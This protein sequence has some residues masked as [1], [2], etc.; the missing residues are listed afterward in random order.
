MPITNDPDAIKIEIGGK[1]WDHW[2][3]L[4]VHIG[5]DT[6]PTAGFSSPWDPSRRDM[7]DAF[8]PC[9][10][11]PMT[12]TRGNVPLFSG[13]IIDP[14]PVMQSDASTVSVNAY[15]R[16]AILEDSNLP[17]EHQPFEARG[18]TL[19]QVAERLAGVYGIGVA[20]YGYGGAPFHKVN[21]KR[22]RSTVDTKVDQE[23]KIDDFLV[24]LAKQR[25]Y[26]RTSDHNGDLL[27]W[28]S[29]K[30]GNPVA[31]L[32]QGTPGVTE[33]IPTFS[34]RDYYSEITG[35]T[36]GKRGVTSSSFTQRNNRLS[37]V[38]LRAMSFRLDDVEKGDAPTAVAAKYGRMLA[39][40]CTY[41]VHVPSW[42]GPHGRVWAVN[43][44]V[45]LEAPL[46]MVYGEYEFLVRDVYLKENNHERT[47][48]LGL[49]VPESFRGEIPKRMPWDE[50][51]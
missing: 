20:I 44:T 17:A 4:E 37:G 39:N 47:A 32:R 24:E 1:A 22:Y 19:P 23:T 2:D 26:V 51:L 50:P 27:F 7:R 8:R 43:E 16:A 14:N 40:A 38:V 13:F 42:R 21:T 34:P 35:Y 48:S 31:R 10:Y 5:L 12:L 49:V 46:A 33:V 45:T 11:T 3:D 28:H 30:P 29:A 36:A 18:L 15:S 25:G 41:V 9:S 6:H